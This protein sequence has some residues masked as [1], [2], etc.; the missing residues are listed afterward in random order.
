VAECHRRNVQEVRLALWAVGLRGSIVITEKATH[1]LAAPHAPALRPNL[2]SVDQFVAKPLVVALAMVVE[3]EVGERTPEVPFTQR[4]HP[5]QAFLFDGPNEAF[6]MR[7]AVRGTERN[8]DH[9]HTR[10]LEQLPNRKA[11]LPIAVADQ[12]AVAVEHALVRRG[13]LADNLTYKGLV[14][15]RRGADDRDASRVQL[16]HKQRVVRDQAADGPKPPS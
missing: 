15:M 1:P 10:R 16:D 4:N 5:I 14:W 12:D 3:H 9:A 7:I 13:Q 8:L 11:P 6:R 2:R